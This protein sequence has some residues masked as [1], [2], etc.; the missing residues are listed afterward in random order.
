MGAATVLSLFV[1]IGNPLIVMAIMG[2]MGYRKRTGFMAGR[3]VAQISESSTVFVAMGITLGHVGV[4][5]LGLTTLVGLITI[6][7]SSCMILYSH[8]LFEWLAPWLRLFE[9]KHPIREQAVE[10]QASHHEPVEVIVIGLGR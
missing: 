9:R 7:V 10:R 4:T 2:W 1:L 5:T 3:T 8:V 6:T